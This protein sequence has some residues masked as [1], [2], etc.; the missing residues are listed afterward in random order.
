MNKRKRLKY[1]ENYFYITTFLI[2]CFFLGLFINALAEQTPL[3]SEFKIYKEECYTDTT[4]QDLSRYNRDVA[5]LNSYRLDLL[6]A[7]TELEKK[8]AELYIKDYDVKMFFEKYETKICNQVE[9]EE[10]TLDAKLC[11][12]IP[13]AIAIH[14]D[15]TKSYASISKEDLTIKWFDENCGRECLES[16]ETYDKCVKTFTPI[17]ES[18]SSYTSKSTESFVKED[19]MEYRNC[20]NKYK[21]PNDYF[22][23]VIK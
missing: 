8:K 21:C 9:V 18:V 13:C 20:T 12:N 19:C 7:K 5:R 6:E 10:I 2:G 14:Q 4:Y 15:G 3:K 17:R 16:G 22:V 1:L 23:E 11:E